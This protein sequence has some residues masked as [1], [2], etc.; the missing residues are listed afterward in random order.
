MPIVARTRALHP[1][2]SRSVA[3]FM[4]GGKKAF[5]AAPSPDSYFVSAAGR[6]AGPVLEL[7]ALGLIRPWLGSRR[8]SRLISSPK[9][10]PKA[11]AFA[12]V[13]EHARAGAKALRTGA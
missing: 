10:W 13:P 6:P 7:L 2:S 11:T 5:A 9:D 3:V 4:K 8:S 12:R 1:D